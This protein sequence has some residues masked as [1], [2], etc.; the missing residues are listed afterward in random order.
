[1]TALNAN[2]T[3]MLPRL[4]QPRPT[5]PQ[6]HPPSALH[7]FWL[8]DTMIRAGFP[9]GVQWQARPDRV[10]RAN[11]PE[12]LKGVHQVLPSRLRYTAAGNL[13]ALTP[14]ACPV[15][16]ASTIPDA[17]VPCTALQLCLRTYPARTQPPVPAL[18]EGPQPH[19]LQAD[20]A[21]GPSAGPSCRPS[22]CATPTLCGCLP[23]ARLSSSHPAASRRSPFCPLSA[24]PAPHPRQQ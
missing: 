17:L 24:P 23:M 19:R 11:V 4:R 21:H 10:V 16:L 1:M 9:H 6:P 15:P 22:A 20:L 5:N 12:Y 2:A 14:S 13:C 18:S 3:S 8:P 7:L